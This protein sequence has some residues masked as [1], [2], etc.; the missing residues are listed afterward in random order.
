[1]LVAW[2][3]S[4]LIIVRYL[5]LVLVLLITSGAVPAHGPAHDRGKRNQQVERTAPADPRVTVSACTLSGDFTVRSWS[6]NEVRVRVSGSA[7]VELARADQ[8]KSEQATELRLTSRRHRE[9][10]RSSCLMF[11]DV[12]LDVPRGANL[13]L[14]TTSG[15]ISVVDVARVNVTTTSGTIT[16][17][18]IQEETSATVIGGNLSVR[19]STGAFRLHATGGDIE[20]RDL[21]PVA[22]SDSVNVSTVSGEVSF[23]HV[24]HQRVSVNSVS[25]VLTYS[26]TLL[27]NGSYSFQNLSGEVHLLLPASASFRLLAS[28]GESVKITSAFDLKYAE[29]QNG[30]RGNRGAPHSVNATIGKGDAL[31]RVS[32]LTGSLRISKQ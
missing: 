23:T 12:E 25:G 11:G 26:G 14:T 13:K 32:L 19:D 24:Q 27:S 20:A 29:N 4:S 30:P 31:I 1:M 2:R 8:A 22:A 21:A 10:A 6:R 7:E 28:L 16:L 5:L 18:K 3:D 9:S 15:D 17:A